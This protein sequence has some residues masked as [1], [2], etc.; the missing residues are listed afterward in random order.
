MV[1]KIPVGNFSRESVQIVCLYRSA[2]PWG[3]KFKIINYGFILYLMKALI[4][5]SV[6]L[7]T[8]KRNKGI[9]KMSSYLVQIFQKFAKI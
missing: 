6:F 2:Q 3:I 7:F 4:F 1:K 8:N 9:T 5:V